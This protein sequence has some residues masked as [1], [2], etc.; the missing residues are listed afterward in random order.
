MSKSNSIKLPPSAEKNSAEFQQYF[1]LES[2][3]N[4]CIN[5]V[6]SSPAAESHE[7]L[8]KKVEKLLFL[9]DVLSSKSRDDNA[10]IFQLFFSMEERINK[11]IDNLREELL[12]EVSASTK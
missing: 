3:L 12:R 11:R 8:E 7:E 10:V 5:K 6:R 4:E 2:E 1:G 9:A